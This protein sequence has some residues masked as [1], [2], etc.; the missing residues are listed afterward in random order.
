MMKTIMN[1]VCLLALSLSCFVSAP[2][3]IAQSNSA[4]ALVPV[5]S[6]L[7]EEE[8]DPCITPIRVGSV[9]FGRLSDECP[10]T[11]RS[12]SDAAAYFSFTHTGGPLYIESL[13]DSPNSFQSTLNL[14]NGRGRG[15][16]EVFVRTPENGSFRG[17]GNGFGSGRAISLVRYISGGSTPNGLPAGQYTIEVGFRASTSGDQRG[18]TLSVYGDLVTARATGRLNDTGIAGA[19]QGSATYFSNCV[20]I[21]STLPPQDCHF[22]RDSDPNLGRDNVAIPNVEFGSDNDGQDGFS[23]LKVG[24][25]GEPLP[26]ST[27][28]L[29]ACVK[30]NVTGLMWEVKTD[31]GG[32]HDAGH[33]YTWYNTNPNENGGAS[34]VQNG[35]ICSDSA[36]DTQS[37]VGAVNAAGLCGYNDWRMPTVTELQGLLNYNNVGNGNTLDSEFFPHA[38]NTFFWSA[39]PDAFSTSFAWGV[40]FS[41]GIVSV[42]SRRIERGVRLV[43][44]GQ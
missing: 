28:P 42:N 1:K 10:P 7:L 24:A 13:S 43:R 17:E 6:L 26:A 35:G 3:A 22:G 2:L 32:L 12:D 18:F 21:S 14:L 23:F 11:S 44:G 36:C 40:G 15:D 8:Q 16:P 37:F 27:I 34:G 5:I 29:H 4:A 19:G 9:V 20:E 39:S 33:T 38:T 31:D 25:S 41:F 30:D